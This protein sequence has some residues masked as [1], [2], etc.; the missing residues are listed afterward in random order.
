MLKNKNYISTNYFRW[1]E[2]E[3][4][5]KKWVIH[6]KFMLRIHSFS[7][8]HCGHHEEEAP[9]CTPTKLPLSKAV[10]THTHYTHTHKWHAQYGRLRQMHA[11]QLKGHA[12]W[13]SQWGFNRNQRLVLH[14]FR[15][16]FLHSWPLALYMLS[17]G[18]LNTKKLV[19]NSMACPSQTTKPSCGTVEVQQCSDLVHHRMSRL[20][21][22]CCKKHKYYMERI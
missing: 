16:L 13:I 4:R 2:C 19:R 15:S 10:C 22:K 6:C 20:N 7:V 14:V 11:G 3:C 17:H 1:M 21:P 8:F 12:S 9:S 18:V 5:Q